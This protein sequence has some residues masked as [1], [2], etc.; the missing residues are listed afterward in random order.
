[1]NFRAITWQK[2][3]IHTVNFSKIFTN[4]VASLASLPDVLNNKK[5]ASLASLPKVV[6]IQKRLA[7]WHRFYKLTFLTNL[8]QDLTT[9]FA[10]ARTVYYSL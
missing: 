9:K 1:M 7:L 3:T 8:H 4:R 5:V 6:N 2:I 10:C